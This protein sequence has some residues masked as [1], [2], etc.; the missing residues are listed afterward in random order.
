[1]YLLIA[2]LLI[3]LICKHLLII[4]VVKYI[5]QMR[6]NHKISTIHISMIYVRVSYIL[7]NNLY[8]YENTTVYYFQ[9]VFD[10]GASCKE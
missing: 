1:M 5:L 10:C 7:R 8:Y 3:L 4:F 2:V 9:N 6:A